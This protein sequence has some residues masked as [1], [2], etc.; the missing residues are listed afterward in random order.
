MDYAVVRW[1]I[2]FLQW[3]RGPY[4]GRVLEKHSLRAGPD[5]P[6]AMADKQ[7]SALSTESYQ[8]YIY[9]NQE[10]GDY[11]QAKLIRTQS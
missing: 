10:S 4:W 7:P 3:L 1:L 2:M 11:T 5:N 9:T 6:A 8:A